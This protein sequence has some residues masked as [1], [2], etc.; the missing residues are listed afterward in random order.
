MLFFSLCSIALT[1]QNFTLKYDTNIPRQVVRKPF[2][3]QPGGDEAPP[4]C[5]GI[6]IY[7]REGSSLRY[8][9]VL[10]DERC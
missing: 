6:V 1:K 8:S 5:G 10:Q 7:S 2:K 9:S 4:G 3:H